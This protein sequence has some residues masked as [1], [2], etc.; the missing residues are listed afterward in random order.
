MRLRELAIVACASAIVVV[1]KRMSGRKS[2]SRN[3]KNRNRIPVTI[4]SGFL[5]AG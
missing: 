5:G 1:S 4:L 3:E 2:S